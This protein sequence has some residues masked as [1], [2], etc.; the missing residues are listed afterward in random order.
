MVAKL[1]GY[2][3]P[4]RPDKGASRRP[5]PLL[6][7]ADLRFNIGLLAETATPCAQHHGDHEYDDQDSHS[8][9][10][11]IPHTP[12]VRPC[13]E[14][15]R[16]QQHYEHHEHQLN[17]WRTEGSRPYGNRPSFQQRGS[18]SIPSTALTPDKS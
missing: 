9:A 4:N 15:S 14:R 13:S 5:A 17:L 10:R 16:Q 3:A 6:P 8:A 7:V 18:P 11:V 2:L 12:A 1:E